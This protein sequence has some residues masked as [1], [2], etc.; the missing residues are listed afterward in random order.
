MTQSD[1]VPFIVGMGRSGNTLVRVMLDSHPELAIPDEAQFRTRMSY[2]YERYERPGG[3]DR[4]AFISDLAR[5]PSFQRWNLD[6]D[7][8]RAALTRNPPRSFP[9]AIE[10]IFL[11]FARSKGKP[12]FGDKTP[13]A[14]L[15]L[16][17]MA[18]LFPRTRFIHVI[19]DGRD[20]ALSHLSLERG[21]DSVGEAAI[22][23]KRQVERGQSD[24]ALL[25]PGRY[26]EVRYEDLIVHPEA[27]LRSICELI[28]V[29]FDERMLRYYERTPEIYGTNQPPTTHASVYLPP[30]R[31]LRDWRQQM[32]GKDLEIFE[33][34]AGDLLDRLGY[35]RI[36]ESIAP[37]VQRKARFL[38]SYVRLKEKAYPLRGLK[39]Y[40]KYKQKAFALRTL[41]RSVRGESS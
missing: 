9:D 34:I 27:V 15:Q 19:R 18:E 30:T 26:I 40:V 29:D 11:C 7:D 37:R 10:E 35:E 41:I 14:V 3:V 23:W 6:I 4:E 12:R 32:K 21:I 39:P 13:E 8:V 5:E 1:P 28:E 16:S 20:V 31:G 17:L 22:H 36:A 33:A 38:E 2:E 24:G 25:G